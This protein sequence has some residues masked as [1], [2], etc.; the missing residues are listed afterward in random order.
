[1][2]SFWHR[3][4]KHYFSV[5]LKSS[6]F[7]EIFLGI[8][9]LDNIFM[10]IIDSFNVWLHFIF[11]AL[12]KFSWNRIFSILLLILSF[13]RA[14]LFRFWVFFACFYHLPLSLESIFS[15]YLFFFFL[16][17]FL[18]AVLTHHKIHTLWVCYLHF[19]SFP[20]LLRHYFHVYLP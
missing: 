8:G 11:L 15:F 7:T 14:L 16:V 10:Y 20:L 2:C 13:L 19:S 18:A 5:S 12:G 3:C 4:L 17:L 9:Y 1:M 6:N